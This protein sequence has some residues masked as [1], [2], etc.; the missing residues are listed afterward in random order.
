MISFSKTAGM[1][2]SFVLLVKCHRPFRLFHSFLFMLGLG[3]SG[4]GWSGFTSGVHDVGSLNSWAEYI[5]RCARLTSG[6]M[7]MDKQ[8]NTLIMF[9]WLLFYERLMLRFEINYNMVLIDQNLT[10]LIPNP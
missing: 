5:T 7:N 6:K 2:L 4:K 9:I 1:V 3:Y 8:R 10:L